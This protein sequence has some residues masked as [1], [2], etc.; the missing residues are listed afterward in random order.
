[1]STG[2]PAYREL[3]AEAP[4]DVC[5]AT[6]HSLIMSKTM[7]LTDAQK[8]LLATIAAAG[9]TGVVLDKG[10]VTG[11]SL[12]RKGLVTRTDVEVVPA[13]RLYT[14]RSATHTL[15]GRLRFVTLARFVAVSQ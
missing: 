4:L 6:R 5:G 13:T 8:A 15:R 3:S 10:T 7:S 9:A 1:M 11:S 14:E 12:L 2:N